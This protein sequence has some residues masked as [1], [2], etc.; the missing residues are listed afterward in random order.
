MKKKKIDL[1]EIGYSDTMKCP[2]CREYIDIQ[3]FS[4]RFAT[5][6]GLLRDIVEEDYNANIEFLE[7]VLDCNLSEELTDETEKLFKKKLKEYYK[8]Y[9]KGI[10]RIYKGTS[11]LGGE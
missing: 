3:Y 9:K 5:P 4:G 7:F 2:E 1:N 11:E 8:N 10:K 6:I